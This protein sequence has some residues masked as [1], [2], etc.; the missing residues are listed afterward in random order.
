MAWMNL[1][2]LGLLAVDHILGPLHE[3][4]PTNHNSANDELDE[5]SLFN[6]TDEEIK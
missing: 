5:I 3:S 6:S 4:D 1:F 2:V